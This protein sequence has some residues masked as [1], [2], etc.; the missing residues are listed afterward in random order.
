MT[1]LSEFLAIN[2]KA[3]NTSARNLS[4]HKEVH[5]VFKKEETCTR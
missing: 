3:F 4:R 2:A 5:R 1:K